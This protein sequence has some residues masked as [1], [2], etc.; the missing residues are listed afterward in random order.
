MTPEAAVAREGSSSPSR[1]RLP[2]RGMPQPA[3]PLAI[4]RLTLPLS[5]IA[6]LQYTISPSHH[7]PSAAGKGGLPTALLVTQQH[8]RLCLQCLTVGNG[9]PR[10]LRYV[11]CD[12]EGCMRSLAQPA[13]RVV[14]DSPSHAAAGVPQH[15]CGTGVTAIQQHV[16]T[17][18]SRNGNR[19][20]STL[21]QGKLEAQRCACVPSQAPGRCTWG[22]AQRQLR[23]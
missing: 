12:V 16:A 4:L 3:S 9:T 21:Q 5:E 17:T 6:A 20:L 13:G 18:A 14:D 23:H 2:S 15:L 7:L 1:P 11:R 10:R 22:K 8:V 19:L